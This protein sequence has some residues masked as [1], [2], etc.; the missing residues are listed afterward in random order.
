VICGAVILTIG[1][2]AR[3]IFGIFHQQQE[4]QMP[5]LKGTAVVTGATDGVGALYA[6]G[7][8]V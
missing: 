2:G 4:L 5:D 7:G 8:L 1:I 6:A 3:Q